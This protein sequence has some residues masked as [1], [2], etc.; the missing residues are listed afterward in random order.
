MTLHY[1]NSLSEEKKSIVLR[2]AG[3]LVARTVNKYYEFKLFQ[4]NSF[5][6]EVISKIDGTLCGSR[7]FNSITQLDRYL[8]SI[9]ISDLLVDKKY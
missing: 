2:K 6:V 5:Y 7:A 1:Y 8:N 3:A 4:V 9:D